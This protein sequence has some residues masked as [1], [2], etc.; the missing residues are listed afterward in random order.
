MG[1]KL[2]GSSV[3]ALAG[4]DWSGHGRAER[5]I[6]TVRW[7][8]DR[9]MMGHKV[10]DWDDLQWQVFGGVVENKINN[11]ILANNYSA[12]QR[13]TGRNTHLEKSLLDRGEQETLSDCSDVVKKIISV[14]DTANEAYWKVKSSRALHAILGA[15]TRPE[16]M[17]RLLLVKKSYIPM[18]ATRLKSEPLRGRDLL[19]SLA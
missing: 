3:Q 15:A 18:N 12:S 6:L 2:L 10:E 19:S 17:K 11:E 14:S 8:F 13:V 5:A 7:S 9:G 16:K 1:E 4:R